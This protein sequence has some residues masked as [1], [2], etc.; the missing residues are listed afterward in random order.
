MDFIDKLKQ[1]STRV[2]KLKDKI[3][4]EE[5]TKTSLIMPFF[6]LLGYDVFNPDEFLPEFIADVGIKK[7]EKVDYAIMQDGEPLILIEA[8]ECNNEN[9]GKCTSQLFRYFGTTK[10]KFA[11]L[12]NGIKYMFYTDLEELNRMDAKPFFE[13]NILDIKDSNVNE[14]KKFKKENLDVETILNTASE[15]KYTNEIIQL[16]NNQFQNPS[17]SFINF[18][19]GE[20]YSGRKTQNV[21]DKFRDTIKN[22][23]NQFINELMSEKFKSVLEKQSNEKEKLN[24]EENKEEANKEVNKENEKSKIITTLEELEAFFIIKSLLHKVIDVERIT[25]KDTQSYFAILLENNTWKWICRVYL[26]EN[27]KFITIPD[28][29]KNE[30]R[31]DLNTIH[32]IYNYKDKIEEVVKRY[33]G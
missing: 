30:I 18:I 33:I 25:Y 2:K 14:L 4:T 21:I 32:D 24:N 27:A 26:R 3:T 31:Y 5:A 19:L 8:K 28:S 12:T 29:N 16:M 22:S 9:L 15:L 10:A 1:F 17:D 20:I 23:L 13:F 7:G 11:I 6:Q